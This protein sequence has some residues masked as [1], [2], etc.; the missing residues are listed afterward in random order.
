MVKAIALVVLLLI[1]PAAYAVTHTVGDSSGWTTGFDYA[2]WASGKNFA[3]GD[4]LVFTYGPSHAVDEVS[5]GGCNTANPLGSYTSSP[6]TINL[7]TTG[8]RYFICPR[9]NHCSQGQR[10]TVTVAAA[11]STS[12]PPTG[13]SAPSTPAGTPPATPGTPPSTAGAAAATIGCRHFGRRRWS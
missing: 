12:P 3:V 8:T 11:G 2:T 10:L 1:S 4:T 13:G 5:Q 6:T 9:S 7:N